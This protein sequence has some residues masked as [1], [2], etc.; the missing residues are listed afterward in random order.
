MRDSPADRTAAVTI[1][2]VME[3]A[4]ATSALLALVLVLLFLFLLLSAIPLCGFINHIVN[5]IELNN[6]I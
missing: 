3:M 2:P 6:F 5:D 4:A 1:M